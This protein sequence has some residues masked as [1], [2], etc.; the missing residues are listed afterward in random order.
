MNINVNSG[1]LCRGQELQD[2]AGTMTGT[3]ASHKTADPLVQTRILV[4]FCASAAMFFFY[5]SS[6]LPEHA[7][8]WLIVQ[9][10]YYMAAIAMRSSAIIL[11][12]RDHQESPH[13]PSFFFP[14]LS[15]HP[16]T[17]FPHCPLHTHTHTHTLTQTH[18][19]QH[20][21]NRAPPALLEQMGAVEGSRLV[22]LILHT[23]ALTFFFLSLTRQVETKANN[24][25]FPHLCLCG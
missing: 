15:F 1:A 10:G 14:S 23:L 20:G 22:S 19:T 6:W 12:R 21:M 25:T 9:G 17:P 18:H 3:D 16:F 2:S 7:A 8:D 24:F 4:S 11:F 13:P 5:A